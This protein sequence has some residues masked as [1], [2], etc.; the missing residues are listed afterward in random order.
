MGIFE[1]FFFNPLALAVSLR[2]LLTLFA[3]CYLIRSC[4]CCQS[5]GGRCGRISCSY[6]KE[7]SIWFIS[8]SRAMGS[9]QSELG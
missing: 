4:G 7:S 1:N 9:F 2:G 8:W 5:R 6:L 3:I